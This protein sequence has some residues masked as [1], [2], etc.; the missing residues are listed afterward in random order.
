[1]LMDFYR[2]HVSQITDSPGPTLTAAPALQ[3]IGWIAAAGF[4]RPQILTI[5]VRTNTINSQSFGYVPA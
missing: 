5:R 4:R 2:D 1:M 3:T